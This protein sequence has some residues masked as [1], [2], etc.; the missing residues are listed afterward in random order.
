MASPWPR[1]NWVRAIPRGVVL[2]DNIPSYP[3]LYTLDGSDP[4]TSPTAYVYSSS[5]APDPSLFTPNVSLRVVALANDPTHP[6]VT[7]SPVASYTLTPDSIGLSPPAFVTSN[8]APLT[9]GTPVVISLSGSNG[10]P[11]TEVNNGAPLQGSSAATS[12]PLN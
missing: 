3:V 8:A 6:W 11:R 12:F 1:P 4:T 2:A 7:S 9:P 5:F 10:S